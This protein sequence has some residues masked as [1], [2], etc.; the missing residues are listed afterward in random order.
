[1]AIARLRLQRANLIA[2]TH[3]ILS[4]VRPKIAAARR[5]LVAALVVAAG[6]IHGGAVLAQTAPG[7]LAPGNAAVTGFSGAAAPQ[8]IAPGADPEDKTFIDLNGATFRI[9]DLQNMGGPPAAQLVSA[10]K[11]YTATA[12]QIGQVFAVA[13]DNATPPNIYVAATSA[14]GLPIVVGPNRTKRGRAGATFMPGLFGPRAQNGG[15]GSIWK[16]DGRSGA[17][18]RFANVTLNGADNPGPALGGLAFDPGSN[19]LLAADRSTGMIHR[20]DLSGAER[21]VYDHGI[22]GRLA[23]QLPPLPYDPSRRLDITKPSFDSTNPGTWGFT[24]PDRLI[25]GLA[26]RAGRLYYAVAVNMQIWSVGVAPNGAFGTDARVEITVPPSE[27][28]SEISKITFDDEGRM[29]LAER[30]IPTGDYGFDVLTQE[31]IGRVLRYARQ[32]D[33]TWQQEPDEY[34]IGFPLH[35]RNGNGGVAV[36]YSYAATGAIDRATC[37][38][39]LWS[40]GEQLRP[41]LPARLDH[42]SGDRPVPAAAAAVGLSARHGAAA[43]IPMLSLRHIHECERSVRAA[44]PARRGPRPELGRHPQPRPVLGGHRSHDLQPGSPGLLAVHRRQHAR[45]G[46]RSE[47]EPD[48]AIAAAGLSRSFGRRRPAHLSG[49]IHQDH[50]RPDTGLDG[51]SGH[52]QR[53]DLRAHAATACLPARPADRPR[54]PVSPNL[55]AW[56]RRISVVAGHGPMLRGRL[57][58]DPDRAVL[59]ARLDGR[60]RHRAVPDA[61][62]RM[63]TGRLCAR[64]DLRSGNLPVRAAAGRMRP[65]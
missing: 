5:G 25:F 8:T 30:P 64:S 36:G 56:Q 16:I 60:S 65:E 21:G 27:G 11:P 53:G 61:A 23:A 51:D 26:V 17:I 50:G 41:M 12:A 6:T 20:F 3:S 15:P 31:G 42:R 55:P 35:L 45:P 40:T 52:R 4:I 18:T 34:A 63:P 14:Y 32:P 28:P 22:Q 54:R 10:P 24:A 47:R 9:I 57:G 59:P 2:A 29:L 1:M 43:R 49:R 19:T 48:A 7:I 46:Q 33:G 58:A 37:G 13:L 44:L 39:Y 62:W 38:G